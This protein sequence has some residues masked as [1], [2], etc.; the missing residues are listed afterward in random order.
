MNP[1]SLYQVYLATEI[2]SKAIR[3][4]DATHGSLDLDARTKTVV[5][6]IDGLQFWNANVSTHV[7]EATRTPAGREA[8]AVML[9]DALPS[10]VLRRDNGLMT[11]VGITSV[12]VSYHVSL[13][14]GVCERVQVGTERVMVADPA[15]P[16]VEVV[17]PVFEVRCVDPITEALGG[18]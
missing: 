8:L 14:E 3:V 2:V 4:S 12:G 13:G 17:R 11:I 6:R 18:K 5:D 1:F 16:L 7:Y 15:A 10:P 9:L